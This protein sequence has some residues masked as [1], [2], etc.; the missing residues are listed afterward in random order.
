VN[1]RLLVWLSA[2]CCL[3]AGTA[4]GQAADSAAAARSHYRQAVDFLRA[5]DTTA[6]LTSLDLAAAAWPTQGFYHKA[7]ARLA[8]VSG[9]QAEALKAL[10]RLVRLGYGWEQT[11]PDLIPLAASPEYPALAQAMLAATGPLRRSRVL[12]RLSDTLLHPE[13]IAWDGPRRRWL[14]SSVRQRKVVAVDENGVARDLVRSGQNGLDAALAIAVDSSRDLL[15][16][17][18][19]ALPQQE[20]WMPADRGRSALFA[21]DLATG[22]LRRRV[23]LPPA[24]A[25]HS[26]GDLT[27]TADGTVYA[28]DNGSPAVYLVSNTGADTATPI[29]ADTPMLRS[30]QGL[31]Y[32]G[33]RLLVADYSLGIMEV[34]LAS[35]AVRSLPSPPESTVLGIDGLV[36][37]DEH[38]LLGVQNGLVPPRIVRL[39]LAPDGRA[40]TEVTPVDRYLPEAT[41]PTQGVIVDGAFVYLANSPWS[42]YDDAG[43]PRTGVV[44]PAPLL[45]RLPLR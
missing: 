44:W 1:S 25:G 36:R 37:L 39:A 4:S 6:A 9:R 12:L 18:S 14:I 7:Y 40:I 22:A 23:Q 43:A 17:A 15:W 28:S 3:G 24:S 32:D 35:G 16:V 38:H 27:V 41:E 19:A 21:F 10:K 11:D 20:G 30:P 45:L 5:G 33:A 13:G 2:L 34:D 8:A 29:A 31:V 26:V 42:N